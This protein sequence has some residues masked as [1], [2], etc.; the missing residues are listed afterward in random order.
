MGFSV[1]FLLTAIYLLPG[2]EPWARVSPLVA[3][4]FDGA[5]HGWRCLRIMAWASIAAAYASAW[6]FQA[7]CLQICYP[8]YYDPYATD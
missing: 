8:D 6:T 5:P 4:A 7:R 3:E 1:T 2:L